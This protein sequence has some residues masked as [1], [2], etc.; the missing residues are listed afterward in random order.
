MDMKSKMIWSNLGVSNLD[1]TT[2]FY[3]KLGFQYNGRSNELVSF[4]IGDCQFV[5]NFFIKEVLEAN[6]QSDILEIRN[7]NEV[8]FTLSASTKEE[9]NNWFEE[10]QQAG[11]IINT[12]P[13][14]FGQD[15]Y[16]FVFSDP[17]GHKFNIFHM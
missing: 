3:N 6:I 11:G 12:K 13:E 17:D 5:I 10:V 8:I 14:K 2:E 1:R 15:Y 4:K 9:V 7:G 16:G